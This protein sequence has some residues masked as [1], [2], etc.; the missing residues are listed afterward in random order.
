[1]KTIAFEEDDEE[2]QGNKAKAASLNQSAP[3]SRKK[4]SSVKN[5]ETDQDS[6]TDDQLESESTTT[7]KAIKPKKRGRP[8][9]AE[10]KKAPTDVSTSTAKKRRRKSDVI[11][12]VVQVEPEASV[13]RKK[14]FYPLIEASSNDIDRLVF[15]SANDG[16]KEAFVRIMKYVCELEHQGLTTYFQKQYPDKT[17]LLQSLVSFLQSLPNDILEMTPN[18]MI[19]ESEYSSDEKSELFELQTLV[20]NQ[21]EY[22]LKLSGYENDIDSFVKEF[23]ICAAPKPA[24]ASITSSTVSVKKVSYYSIGTLS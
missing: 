19:F 2:S 1:V 20:R 4:E 6:D 22:A 8:S 16:E 15:E 24:T 18:D 17:R 23:N 10:S 12:D 5:N 21:E 7:N 3:E 11:D 14:A 13:L 9:L